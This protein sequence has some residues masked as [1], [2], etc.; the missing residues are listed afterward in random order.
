MAGYA[1]QQ[2]LPG[3]LFS[4]SAFVGSLSLRE[5]SI[6]GQILGGFIASVGIYLPGT[7]MIFFVIRF[8]DK[9]KKYRAVKASL[10][11]VNAASGGIILATAC[12]LIQPVLTDPI[13][14]IVVNFLIFL[15]TL[16]LLIYTKIPPP[17][18]ILAGLLIGFL[19]KL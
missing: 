11:G 13:E 3:P 14:A 18:F 5:Y 10:E 1:L 9:L 12:Q 16:L 15:I 17:Y 2:A 6:W 4:F 8:W 19:F 7:L